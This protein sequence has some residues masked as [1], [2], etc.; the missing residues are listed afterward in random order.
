MRCKAPPSVPAQ[1][2]D[3]AAP[4]LADLH[5][6]RFRSA[7]FELSVPFPDGRAWRIDDH[8]GP[9]LV[10][11]H[12]ATSSTFTLGLWSETELMNRQRCEAAA[13]AKGLVEDAELQTVADEVIVGPGQYDTH[14]T[15]AAL[16]SSVPHR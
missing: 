7:R 13:R 2:V 10:A 4:F 9:Y 14:I 5:P 6:L 11:T 1:P 8:R 16:P 3:P 12:P 15:V